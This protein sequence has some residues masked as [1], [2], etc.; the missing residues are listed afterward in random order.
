MK[1]QSLLRGYL[2]VLAVSIVALMSCQ[3][4]KSLT[5]GS[6]SDN[7][8][9]VSISSVPGQPDLERVVHIFRRA[10][11]GSGNTCNANSTTYKLEGTKWPSGANYY[12]RTTNNSGL[13]S[14]DILSALSTAFST[15]KTAEPAGPTFTYAG[16]TLP[17]GASYGSLT[18][19]GANTVAF[20]D[21]SS[22]GAGVL[23]VT[24]YIYNRRTHTT[25]EYDQ[26]FNDAETW[27]ILSTADESCLSNSTGAFD[28]LNIA[29]HEDGHVMGLSDLYNGADHGLTMY[30]YAAPQETNKRTLGTGD[31]NGIRSI[32]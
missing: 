18:Y 14:S 3:R 21:T 32:Y 16:E 2:A 23:A 15:W 6:S 25:I 13:T 26:V 11:P 31:T 1:R 7:D 12:V 19:D 4:Y 9:S 27:E 17:A 22:Y 20:G 28:F 24:G 29:T 8:G 5:S 10:R 30:G